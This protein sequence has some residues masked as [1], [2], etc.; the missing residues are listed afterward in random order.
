VNK[1]EKPVNRCDCTSRTF[2]Q[3]LALGSLEAAMEETEAG[4]GCEGCLPYLKL[5]FATGETAFAID[6][7]R[8][9]EYE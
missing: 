1:D 3:L 6:D 2:V 8:L 4:R 9:P 7:P 5:A